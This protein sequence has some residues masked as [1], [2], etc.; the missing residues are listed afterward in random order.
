MNIKNQLYIVF[1]EEHYNPLGVIRS[2]GEAGIPVIAIIYKCALPY[3][4][5][6]SQSKYI[7]TL[8][9]VDTMEGGYKLLLKKYGDLPNGKKP[10]LYTCDDYSTS[11]LD[12][13]FNEIKDKFIFFNCGEQG[14]LTYYQDK[15]NI[16]IAAE[17]QGLN[18]AESVVV[19]RGEIPDGLEYPIITKAINSNEGAWKG[20]VFICHSEKELREAYYKI[21]SHTLLLQKYIEKKNEYC[22]DGFSI[23]HGADSFFAIA[24]TYD[25]ILP[26]RYSSKMTVTNCMEDDL[27]RRLAALLQD[28]QFEGIFSIEFLIGPDDKFYFLEVNLRNS[29]WSYASTKLGMNLPVLWSKCLLQGKI[30]SS[31]E[32]KVPDDYH[33]MVELSDFKAR[34][35][36]KKISIFQWLKE[37]HNTNCLF[38]Y[39]KQDP[40]PFWSAVR[41]KLF[42]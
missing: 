28:I 4:K 11:Y 22:I 24:S 19:K 18:V 20:D 15:N 2:L 17:K 9:A 41:T 25:Y 10:F 40:K 29:T 12:Q 32:K 1:G 30:D 42:K 13:H 21:K 36:G 34:V 39:S 14:R 35:I 16:N 3:I 38:Y 33:A 26:D 37:Y 7:S 23:N 31:I 5:I 8:H 6:A 27:K